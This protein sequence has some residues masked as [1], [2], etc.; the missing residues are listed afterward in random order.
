VTVEHLGHQATDL[1]SLS[2]GEARSLSKL[3]EMAV[4]QVPGCAA[5]HATIWRDGEL[6]AVSA[7]HPDPAELVDLEVSTGLGPLTT[8]VSD[9]KPVSCADILNDERWPQ[10]AQEALRRGLRSSVHL[11]RQFPPMTLV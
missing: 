1:V 8:A 10:W 7:S 3:A 9:G 5:A 2:N 4:R 6:A 11:V